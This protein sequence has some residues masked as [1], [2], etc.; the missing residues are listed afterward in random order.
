[1]GTPARISAASTSRSPR[2]YASKSTVIR[3]R[4]R[5]GQEALVAA[6]ES[7]IA[8]LYSYNSAKAALARARGEGDESVTKY[9]AGG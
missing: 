3:S 8:S 2:R 4:S 5:T 6:D 1:M 9:F 7:L